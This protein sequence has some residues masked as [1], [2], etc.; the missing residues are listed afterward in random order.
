M[1]LSNKLMLSRTKSNRSLCGFKLPAGLKHLAIIMDGQWPVGKKK[2][3]SRGILV[4]FRGV[5]SLSRIVQLCANKKTPLFNRIC[6][7]YRKTGKR[8]AKEICCLNA[9][10]ASLTCSLPPDAGAKTG[11]GFIHCW[12]IYRL[13]IPP[14]KKLLKDIMH[15]TKEK[16]R[17]ATYFGH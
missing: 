3:S 1:T 2:E 7:Q 16:Q 14:H 11:S 12:A 10:A 4:H 9:T 13:W 17:A 8:P 5:H 15:N 6:L